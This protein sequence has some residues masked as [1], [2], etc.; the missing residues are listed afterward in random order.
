MPHPRHAGDAVPSP[1]TDRQ[2]GAQRVMVIGSLGWS[3]VN[4]RLDLLRRMVANGHEVIAVAPDLDEETATALRAAG[5]RARAVQM[6]RTGLNPLRDM[7]TLRGLRD[8]MRD[9]A[10]DVVLP[11][12]MKPIIYG[13]LAARLAGIDRCYPLF[14][15]LGYA[16][17]Q[18]DPHGK[19]RAIRSLVIALH[20]LATRHIRQAFY[21]NQAERADIRRFRLLPRQASLVH[22]PGT[23]V[24]P[25]RFT[26][27]PPPEG[28][29]VFLFVGRMLRIKGVDDLIA[30]A[31]IL[32]AEGLDFRL[33]LLGPTDSNPDALPE[34]ALIQWQQ[35]GDLEYLG[36]TRDVR[37]YLADCA[38]LVLP[39]KLREG[40][41]RTILEA[42]ASGRAVITSDAPGCGETVADRECGL[43][44]PAGDIDRLADAMRQIIRN[45]D[46]ATRM[47][48][49]A[50][51][52]VC[53]HHDVHKINQLLLTR[54]GLEAEGA[55]HEVAA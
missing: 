18:D 43:V 47:G 49:A 14:T 55:G 26:P 21:Y 32:R 34:A 52:R 11:Y 15:G 41:P 46:L 8:L 44:V 35:Q 5:V 12:T 22:V 2:I 39:S 9:E 33:R 27:T 28:V 54:M 25:A 3:L 1:K 24:D 4:F 6:Q 48:A 50:R 13:S 7:Q 19:R 38:A 29:P 30:A 20:R 23:G 16:F 40:V 31:R 51:D 53:R 17:S 10:P 36:A 37:P 42:M 45:P